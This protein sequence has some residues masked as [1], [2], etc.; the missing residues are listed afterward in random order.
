MR[1]VN[2]SVRKKD[3]MQLVTGQPVYVDDLAPQDCLIVKLLRSPYANAMV[4]TINT[5]IAMK[6]P[7]IEAI[8]TWEDVPK[9]RFTMAGQ[10][11]PEPG[12]AAGCKAL[13]TGGADIPGG[14]PV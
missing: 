12:C 5:A 13:H 4:K 3:A 6:V 1:V 9:Q 8:Y 2:T 7:G 11:Y 10:T 14:E